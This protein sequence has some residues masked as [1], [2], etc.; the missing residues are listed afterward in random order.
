MSFTTHTRHDWDYQLTRNKLKQKKDTSRPGHSPALY[1]LISLVS[2]L[3]KWNRRKSPYRL[4]NFDNPQSYMYDP[5]NERP[6]AQALFVRSQGIVWFCTC[7]ELYTTPTN[8][9]RVT[10]ISSWPVIQFVGHLPSWS[11]ACTDMV[12]LC[13]EHF[14]ATLIFPTKP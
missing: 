6:V 2:F 10:L 5:D 9:S 11:H 12:H 13:Y 14:Q 4:K 3:W 8:V 7:A 1:V